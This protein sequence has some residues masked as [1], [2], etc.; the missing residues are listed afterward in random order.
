MATMSGIMIVGLA[1]LRSL[2][3]KTCRVRGMEKLD[4]TH[5]LLPKL[6][7]VGQFDHD[8]GYTEV[9]LNGTPILCDSEICANDR[10]LTLEFPA[11]SRCEELLAADRI[12]LTTLGPGSVEYQIPAKVLATS[13]STEGDTIT[14]LQPFGYYLPEPEQMWGWESYQIERGDK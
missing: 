1:T 8:T 13:T 3:L 5:M 12:V 11:G 14:F 9:R 7:V 2:T 4:R 6:V 10:I